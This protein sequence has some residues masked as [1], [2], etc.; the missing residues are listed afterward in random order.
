MPK[1]GWL[2]CFLPTITTQ[3]NVCLWTTSSLPTC[4]STSREKGQRT[5][6]IGYV[7]R[8]QRGYHKMREKVYGCLIVV[9]MPLL[10]VSLSQAQSTKDRL[11][12]GFNVGALRPYCDYY[13]TDFAPSANAFAK[14][15]LSKR[16]NL[17]VSL[18][19]GELA[20]NEADDA[21][22]PT[23][24]T[25]LI[26]ADLKGQIAL[27]RPQKFIPFILLGGGVFNF[28][29]ENSD[30]YFDGSL[31]VG[32]GFELVLQPQTSLELYAD[33]RHTTSDA[34][35]GIVRQ[36]KDGYLQIGA[37][38]TYYFKD[39][40]APVETAPPGELVAMKED[41]LADWLLAEEPA[42]TARFQAFENKLDKMEEGE[43]A[44]TM[45]QYL[46]LK[47]KVD[48]LNKT[49]A[50]KEREIE[51]LRTDLDFK[52]DRIAELEEELQKRAVPTYAGSALG[53]STTYEEGLRNFY[54]RQYQAAV[55]TFSTLL[56]DFPYHKLASNCQYWIGE[57]YFGMADYYSAKD[58]FNKVFDYDFS[59][60]KDD[61]TLMLGRCYMKLGDSDKARQMLESLLRDFPDSEYVGKAEQHLGSLRG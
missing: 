29:Y 23:F 41:E 7:R 16:F 33:Y 4:K 10:F 21:T 55:E 47:S 38:L 20:D 17:I 5:A 50:D 35:D 60:K 24:R 25:N 12:L 42:D 11:G 54:S 27:T 44:M 56:M 2:N 43:S 19:Y 61:A 32:G 52:R 49:I 51:S 22:H 28:Q 39:R 31:L 53:F 26:A 14:F 59:Y 34:I 40:L 13:N 3:D 6:K 36:E 48:E 58:A 45:E 15:L 57:S 46:A 1:A 18:G 37:G 9:C 8:D 30:R